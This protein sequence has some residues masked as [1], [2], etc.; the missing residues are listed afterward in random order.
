MP[1][2]LAGVP[3]QFIAFYKGEQ[4]PGVF[5]PRGW[6]CRV[7]HG[8]SG[9]AI[10]VTPMPIDSIHLFPPPPFRGPAVELEVSEGGTSGRFGVAFGAARLFPSVAAAFIDAVKKEG[11][12]PDSEFPR[13]PYPTD[14]VKYLDSLT[15]QFMTPPRTQGLGTQG[16]LAPSQE[17]IRGI[18]VLRDPASG[19][20]DLL[21]VRIRLRPDMHP[22][23][24]AL[25]Q[26]N[27]AC[28]LRAGGC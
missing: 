6:H 7:W 19:E 9:S 2:P 12:V 26:L 11:M 15:A 25:L 3:V 13:G 8:S 5:A 20:P 10:V 18:A 27:R 24:A 28:L 4:A 22:M 16:Y 23:D 17:R 1:V 21:T 14:S